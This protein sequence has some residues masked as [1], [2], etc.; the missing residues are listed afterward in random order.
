MAARKASVQLK[1]FG[2]EVK[3]LREE[4]KLNRTELAGRATVSRSYISQVET[5]ST[6]CRRDFAERLDK[7]LGSAPVLTNLWDDLLRST[8]YPRYFT[9]FSVAESTAVLL[10]SYQ[11]T[12][13]DGL[14]QTEAYARV[15]LVKDDAV[16][17]R[18]RRQAVLDQEVPPL[19]SVV[20]D[21]SV[22][23]RQVGTKQVMREQLEHLLALMEREHITLQIA[24]IAY[25]RGARASFTIATQADRTE[26]VYLENAARAETSSEEEDLTRVT[27]TFVRL[28]AS[29]L[30]V[31]DSRAPIERTLV[32]RWT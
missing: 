13:V 18:L 6:R 23:Y 30:T 15:L 24:P 9:D 16:Q 17:A 22:L 5:G 4:G 7:A 28:Q 10:R 31:N 14:F 3:R 20:L 8:G 32:E 25:I 2:A 26:A 1:A 12:Y 19:V 29:A 11:T 27:E 21:E